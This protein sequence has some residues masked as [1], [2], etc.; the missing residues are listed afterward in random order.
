MK[1][2]LLK[3]KESIVMS[4]MEDRKPSKKAF[5]RF[6]DSNEAEKIFDFDDLGENTLVVG[7]C[8]DWKE[9]KHNCYIYQTS[10]FLI[11][12]DVIID[13]KRKE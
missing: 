1:L 11:D 5:Y 7:C 12:E 13:L 3:E 6:P 9:D 2:S 10:N 4:Y 8:S